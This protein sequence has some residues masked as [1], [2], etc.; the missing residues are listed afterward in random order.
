MS[1]ACGCSDEKNETGEAGEEAEG[2]WQVREV[3]A[4]AIAGVLLLVA[5]G[6]GVAADLDGRTAL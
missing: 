4:A 5:A 1:D 6:V 2:F 3:R